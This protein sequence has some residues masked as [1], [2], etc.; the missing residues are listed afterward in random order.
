MS[1][2]QTVLVDVNEGVMTITLNRPKAKNAANR[3]LAEG[4][5]AAMDELIERQVQFEPEE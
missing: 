1:E 4:V 2:E 3:A 5:A